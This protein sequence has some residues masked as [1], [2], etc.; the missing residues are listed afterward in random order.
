M[1]TK[2]AFLCSLILFFFLYSAE[3][4]GQDSLSSN[5]IIQYEFNGDG[6]N[7]VNTKYYLKIGDET[8][9][10]DFKWMPGRDGS[11]RSALL[12]TGNS[13]GLKTS[14]NISPQIL[15]ELTYIAWVYDRPDGFLFGSTL[16]V[17]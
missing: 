10:Y 6:T 3:M 4:R 1:E 8:K 5:L 7:I 2:R 14:L 11:E 17:N 16:P 9:N 13:N 12:F 15:P